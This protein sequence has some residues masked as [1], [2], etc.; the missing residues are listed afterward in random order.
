MDNQSHYK[1]TLTA[2]E[3]DTIWW[4]VIDR[5][6]KLLSEAKQCNDAGLRQI[7]ES[8]ARKCYDIQGQINRMRTRCW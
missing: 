5:R 4:S 7:K 1:W 3:L 2:D 6:D 8:L